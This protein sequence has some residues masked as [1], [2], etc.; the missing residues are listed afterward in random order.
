MRCPPRRWRVYVSEVSSGKSK[1]SV[2]ITLP[3]FVDY[4]TSFLTK[5]FWFLREGLIRSG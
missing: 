2:L 1:L 4:Q 5:L 3:S